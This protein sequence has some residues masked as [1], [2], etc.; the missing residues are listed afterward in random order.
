MYTSLKNLTLLSF[1]LIITA[2]TQKTAQRHDGAIQLSIPLEDSLQNAAWSPDGDQILFTNFIEGYNSEPANLHIFT[3]EDESLRILVAD[4]NGNVNLP[5]SAWSSEGNM[6]SFSS[7]REPHD[8]IFIIS[9]DGQNGDER[10]ITRREDLVAYEATFSPDGEWIVFESHKLDVEENGIITRYKI[11]GSGEYESLTAASDDARQPN[12]SPAGDL[13]LYQRSSNEQ[14]DIWI[15]SPGGENKKQL[16]S[17]KGDKTDASFSPDGRFIVYSSDNGELEFA[18]LFVISVDGGTPAQIT[19]YAGYDGAPSWSPNGKW[20]VF[21]SS[22][23]YPDDEGTRLW[24][25]EIDGF[26]EDNTQN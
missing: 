9:A 14:W 4:G 10:A 2:C 19:D 1:F 5:G 17:G 15:M 18:N 11:D 12:Y 22:P 8:E 26:Y 24:K 6:I 3:F 7:S 13:I 20:I 25:I 16:I 21:E 23:G